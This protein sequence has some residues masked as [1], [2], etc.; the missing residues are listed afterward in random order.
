MFGV[1]FLVVA[2]FLIG[3]GLAAGLVA[4]GLTLALMGFG[5]LSSSILIGLQAG[6][7]ETGI[8]AF[9]LQCGVLAGIPAGAMCAWMMKHFSEH[10][11]DGWMVPAY[12]A[13]GGAVAGLCIALTMDAI[14]RRVHVWATQKMATLSS[15]PSV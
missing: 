13:V 4:V 2:L 3:V 7:T 8:R 10:I 15:S 9:L 12:G 14:S 6:R 5:I 11:G 1:I